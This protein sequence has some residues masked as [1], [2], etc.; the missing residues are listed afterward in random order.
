M[1]SKHTGSRI[2]RPRS[3]R[4]TTPDM[5]K[6]GVALSLS[7]AMLLPVSALAAEQEV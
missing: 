3:L 6:T 5:R 1:T 4:N 2:Q 7:T